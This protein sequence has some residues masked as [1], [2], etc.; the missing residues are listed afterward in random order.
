MKIE[1]IMPNG[2]PLLGGQSTEDEAY[3][4]HPSHFFTDGPLIPSDY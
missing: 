3:A 4:F 2:D 1:D